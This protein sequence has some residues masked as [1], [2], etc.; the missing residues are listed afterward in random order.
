MKKTTKR[1]V[2]TTSALNCYLFR[3]LTEG[4]D[5]TQY[6]KNS[7]LLWMHQ[8]PRGLSKDEVLPLGR[9]VDVLIEGDQITCALEFDES[10]PFAMQIY[11]KYENGT[12]CMLSAAVIPLEWSEEPDKM[13]PG[14]IGPTVT[15]GKLLEISCVD[16]GGNDDALPC[17]LYNSEEK[18]IELSTLTPSGII[19]LFNNL[20]ITKNE[21]IQ[22]MKLITLS[23]S[24]QSAILLGLKLQDTATEVEVQNA[25]QGLIT[26]AA[27]Q[28]T[29]ITT[30]TTEKETAQGELNK[31]KTDLDTAVKLANSTK[32]ATLIKLHQGA[33]KFLAGAAPDWTAAAEKDFTGTEKLLNG[34]PASTT[35]ELALNQQKG[36]VW[37]AKLTYADMDKGGKLVKLKTENIEA[38]KAKFKEHFGKEYKG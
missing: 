12:L 11:N 36:E 8:R 22:T 10:D 21:E 24:V 4:L 16:I 34:M 2:V 7:I 37:Y 18:A 13:L 30:L 38:F 20:Q 28:K 9:A 25:V 19:T 15:K 27:N 5:L 26:L 6:L 29:Q 3:I 17:A 33:G 35:L 14:Q 32:V 23:A 1:Y 31:A